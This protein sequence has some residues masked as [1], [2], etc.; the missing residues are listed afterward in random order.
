MKTNLFIQ[1]TSTGLKDRVDEYAQHCLLTEVKDGDET[2]EV[3]GLIYDEE[4]TGPIT[5]V[6]EIVE[7]SRH[8]AIVYGNTGAGK[9]LIFQLLQRVIR[10]EHPRSF[11]L[12]ETNDLAKAFSNTKV[13]WDVF[14]R[15]HDRHVVFN[16]LGFEP[17]GKF[18]K[19]YCEVMEQ[20]IFERELLFDHRQ[21]RTYFTTNLDDDEILKRYGQRTISRIEKLC[22]KVYLGETKN[23]KD[24]RSLK[25]MMGFPPVYH[26]VTKSQE[27]L[28]WDKRYA[29]GKTIA[30]ANPYKNRTHN[31]GSIATRLKDKFDVSP[32][33]M[34]A[35]E[36]DLVRMKIN[37]ILELTITMKEMEVFNNDLDRLFRDPEPVQPLNTLRSIFMVRF[38]P[39]SEMQYTLTP[40][41]EKIQSIIKS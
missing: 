22:H 28:E 1:L 34:L 27:E 8:G 19:D 11:V 41:Q 13:G 33:K 26:Q 5:E 18:Y 4:N 14:K 17:K 39:S 23:S 37:K 20:F 10:P 31:A 40:I 6:I 16:D 38:T 36:I 12:V 15:Y 9:T 2:K 35:A 29:L 21:L 32:E 25:N 30:A 7:K 3:R 24:R